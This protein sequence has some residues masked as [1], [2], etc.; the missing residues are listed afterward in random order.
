[1]PIKGTN[2][3]FIEMPSIVAQYLPEWRWTMIE[4]DTVKARIHPGGNTGTKTSYYKGS[5]IKNWVSLVGPSFRFNQ[6]FIQI[7]NRAPK[8]LW[9]EIK[10]ALKYT[11]DVKYEWQF[12]FYVITAIVIPGFIL[13]PV[14]NWYRHRINRH[15]CT[16]IKREG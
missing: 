14:S 7:K 9:Q 6:G 16:I 15:F 13:R 2:K 4:Y 1:M 3:I 10:A 8:L 11:P 5:Q 12:W